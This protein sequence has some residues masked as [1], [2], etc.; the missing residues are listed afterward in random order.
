MFVIN[1][2]I[3]I[4]NLFKYVNIICGRYHISN[5]NIKNYVQKYLY[6]FKYLRVET[7]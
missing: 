1:R 4:N 2:N 6:I 7:F 3:Y 5:I